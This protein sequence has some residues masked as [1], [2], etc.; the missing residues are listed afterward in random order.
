[1]A[2]INCP[3]CGTEVSDKAKSCPKCAYPIQEAP[4][5][6][7]ERG[8]NFPPGWV[9]FVVVVIAIIAYS[10]IPDNITVKEIIRKAAPPVVPTV[11]QNKHFLN[12]S[13]PDV[14]NIN[15]NKGVAIFTLSLNSNKQ[16]HISVKV[17]DPGK[18]DGYHVIN[19]T[20]KSWSGSTTYEV[21]TTGKHIIEV[22]AQGNWTLRVK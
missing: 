5:K 19:E 3:E 17:I 10:R 1:M 21:H 18:S 8:N 14:F 13:Y 20:G 7:T 2:L 12:G 16:Q 6:Q 15:L 11:V 4:I 9:I 22:E